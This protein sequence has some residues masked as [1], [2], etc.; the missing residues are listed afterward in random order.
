MPCLLVVMRLQTESSG[1]QCYYPGFDQAA[2]L[3]SRATSAS[4]HPALPVSSHLVKPIV[5][6]T[7]QVQHVRERTS[8]LDEVLVLRLALPLFAGSL[9]IFTTDFRSDAGSGTWNHARHG[10]VLDMRV[11]NVVAARQL[12]IS[13]LAEPDSSRSDTTEYIHDELVCQLR[14]GRA[15]VGKAFADGI[16]RF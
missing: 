5:P 4:D 1:R 12:F 15:E 9:L 6:L 14:V 2:P 10:H 3:T 13:I 8:I 11:N 16:D 7:P